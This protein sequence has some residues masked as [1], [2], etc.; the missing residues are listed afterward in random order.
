MRILK[1][2]SALLCYPDED[3]RAAAPDIT[4]AAGNVADLQPLLRALAEEDALD[5]QA[6]YVELFDRGRR[7]S[8]HLFE[9]VHGESRDRGQ[10]MVDL[11]QVYERGGLLVAAGE[12]PDYLPLFLEFAATRPAAEA[13]SLLGEIVPIL[14][15][16]HGVVLGRDPRYAA[17]FAVLLRLADA[18]LAEAIAD[19]GHDLATL[20]AAWEESAV[21]FGPGEDA[22]GCT[23]DRLRTRLRAAG[24]DPR[25]T[26]L[27][28]TA[29]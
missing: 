12:L 17:V 26:A 29:S 23:P 7:A 1:A 16:L 3:L 4:A 14:T 13:K 22:A 28:E 24:R 27:K 9:H 18:P 15:E 19:E 10:A 6:A 21:R 20:D 11:V 5:L 2:L 8:L 25:E